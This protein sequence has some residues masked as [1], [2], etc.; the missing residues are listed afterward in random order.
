MQICLGSS[1]VRKSL[2]DKQALAF[3]VIIP[4]TVHCAGNDRLTAT[5]FY[6]TIP[7]QQ[8]MLAL[9]RLRLTAAFLTASQYHSNLLFI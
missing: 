5:D 4:L 2:W 7:P 9:S 3:K 6:L 8:V 1:S